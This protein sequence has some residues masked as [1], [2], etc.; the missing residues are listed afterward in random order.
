MT[1]HP[2]HVAFIDDG[3][4]NRLCPEFTNSLSIDKETFRLIPYSPSSKDAA[5]T[6]GTYCAKVFSHYCQHIKEIKLSSIDV[7]CNQEK[8]DIRFLAS[9]LTWCMVNKVD[10]INL[11]IG[12]T[13]K[14]D[15]F[16][17]YRMTRKAYKKGCLLIAANKN[18]PT[19]T[20]PASFKHVIGVQ[21][22]H[23]DA[24]C[25]NQLLYTPHD[26]LHLDFTAHLDTSMMDSHIPQSN[27]LAAPFITALISNLF[28]VKGKMDLKDVK[29]ELSQ[30][31]CI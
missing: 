3:I 15:Q 21:C 7:I 19:I 28:V 22:D 24:L 9:A 26:P 8:G 17:L 25:N 16:S 30:S 2:L 20:Y 23:Q 10:M 18:A 29:K 12:S 6:H 13:I 31:F 14:R 1:H 11:S 27:S 4:D 5:L